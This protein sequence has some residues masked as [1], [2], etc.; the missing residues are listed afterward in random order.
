MST[1]RITRSSARSL[2]RY[3]LRTSFMMLGT[4]VGVAAL[5]FVVTVGMAAKAKLTATVH[6]LFGSSSV[7]VSAGGGFFMGGPRDAARLTLD[8]V[9]TVVRDIPGIDTWD[10]MQV[11]PETPARHGARNTSVR[12]LGLSERSER[13]WN[14]GAERGSYFDAADVARS[15]RVALIGE[16]VAR[17]LFPGED[18][19]GQDVLVRS[20]PFRVVGILE[21]FGTDIHGMDRDNE[22][23]VPITA[24]M[25]RVLNV[26]SIRAAK[27]LVADPTEVETVTHE[28][29]RVLRERH[30]LSQGQPDDFTVITSVAVRQMVGR[31]ERVLFLYLP[32]VTA[33]SLL[34]ALAVAASLMLAAVSERT[35]E[36][37]LRRAVGARPTDIRLQ[38]LIE[39]A[40]TTLVGGVVG[41]A[42]GGVVAGM[43]ARHLGLSSTLT[44]GAVALGIFLS[45]ATGLLAGIAPA[46]RAALLAP[47]EALR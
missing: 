33:A 14:R 15:A 35:A 20:V 7:V 45:V 4:L 37:G 21:R 36:I 3:K 2:T 18:P 10:P 24:A 34:A 38:F 27:L 22:I 30:R 12:L 1:W 9:A 8:D 26:D 39:T 23:V 42:V 32:L 43:T 11:A 44:L 17:T 41:L 31:I 13:V 19:L 47:A 40:A 29:V 16:T 25:R 6:Q 46:R 5:T 28:V